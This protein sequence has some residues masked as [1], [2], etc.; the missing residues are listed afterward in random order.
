LW[1]L[2]VANVGDEA[3][4]RWVI[5]SPDARPDTEGTK[6]AMT[7]DSRS[8]DQAVEQL[9]T[10][11]ERRDRCSERY[12]AAQGSPGELRAFTELQAAVD[13]FAA[14]EAWLAWADR[15]Y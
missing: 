7:D 10:A 12:D 2:R 13:T 1:P 11:R 14:R 15:D 4:V 9:Q 3:V 8:R 6:A 5:P